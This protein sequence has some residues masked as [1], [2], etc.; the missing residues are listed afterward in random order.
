LASG[1]ARCPTLCMDIPPGHIAV[2]YDPGAEILWFSPREELRTAE[3]VI[4][5]EHAGDAGRLHAQSGEPRA[6]ASSG[7]HREH[8]CGE[9]LA[10]DVLSVGDRLRSFRMKMR[11]SRRRS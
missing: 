3:A 10:F 9:T 2:K 6:E 8:A 5:E 7:K 11:R 4:D 1:R